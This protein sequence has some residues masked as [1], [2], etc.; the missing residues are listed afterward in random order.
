MTTI[1]AVFYVMLNIQK[2]KVFWGFG[3]CL[4]VLNICF[5]NLKCCGN[6]IFDL[7]IWGNLHDLVAM[8]DLVFWVYFNKSGN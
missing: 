2:L 5:T 4:M 7:H 3:C 1:I 6:L 8:F